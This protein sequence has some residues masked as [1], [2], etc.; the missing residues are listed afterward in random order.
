[1]LIFIIDLFMI[2]SSFISFLYI[3]FHLSFQHDY[4]GH[5][6]CAVPV[7]WEIV[8]PWDTMLGSSVLL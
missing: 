1:M 6:H 4:K 3:A 2:K 8:R 5:Y 7:M